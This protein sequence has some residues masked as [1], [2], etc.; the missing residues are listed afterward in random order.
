MNTSN[1]NENQNP[2][3]SRLNSCDFRGKNPRPISSWVT[4]GLSNISTVKIFFVISLLA[5]SSILGAQDPTDSYGKSFKTL[6]VNFF[7]K[8]SPIIVKDATLTLDSL[9]F[10]HAMTR[11]TEVVALSEI[12]RIRKKVGSFAGRGALFGLGFGIGFCIGDALVIELR[13]YQNFPPDFM[14]KHLKITGASIIVGTVVGLLINDYK[15]IYRSPHPA[16]PWWY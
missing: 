12:S 5:T 13:R 6:S 3:S 9:Y 10:R 2:E 15:T 4:N 14:E 16:W 1:C 11:N 8:P 7:D